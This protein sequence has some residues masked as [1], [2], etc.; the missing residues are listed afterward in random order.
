MPPRLNINLNAELDLISN[1]VREIEHLTLIPKEQLTIN[2]KPDN[3]GP[4]TDLDLLLDQIICSRLKSLFPNDRIVSEESYKGEPLD[5]N[6]GRCWFIDPID[7]TRSFI[8]G[9]DD[10]SIMIG[11]SIDGKAALGVIAQPRKKTL[12]QGFSYQGESVAKKIVA[13]HEVSL[14]FPRN[15]SPVAPRVVISRF[16]HSSRLKNFLHELRP[17]STIR[18]G[19]VGLKAMA[20]LDNEADLYF[21]WSRHIKFWDTC[22]A[23]AILKAAGGGIMD[24]NANE[25]VY[26]E[27]ITHEP[28]LVANIPVKKTLLQ[29]LTDIV[30]NR[31]A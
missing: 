22:A 26:H 11:L 3:E 27:G 17:L 24:L 14:K 13:G 28:F 21:A 7:G 19:S 16:S 4:V 31:P 30:T 18:R 20:V 1:F 9:L 23:H 12:W 10:Y 8:E 29:A 15:N 2:H 25:L 5:N 6:S